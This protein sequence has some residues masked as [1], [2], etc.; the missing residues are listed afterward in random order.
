V[1]SNILIFSDYSGGAMVRWDSPK[2]NPSNR[3][4]Y[5]LGVNVYRAYGKDDYDLLN[6]SAVI[7]TTSYTDNRVP[8]LKTI[9]P[10]SIQQLSKSEWQLELN[11]IPVSHDYPFTPA[12]Q[13]GNL[14]AT[15]DLIVAYTGY[16]NPGRIPVTKIK[17]TKII[18]SD[19]YKLEIPKYEFSLSILSKNISEYDI[20]YYSKT[21][22][23]DHN[24]QLGYMLGLVVVSD[25]TM[26]PIGGG[27][28]VPSGDPVEIWRSDITYAVSEP[29]DYIWSTA[30]FY[31]LWLYNHVCEPV[32]LL[33]RKYT[34]QYCPD[35]IEQLNNSG[36][37]KADCPVC[38]GTGILGGYGTAMAIKITPM[39]FTRTKEISAGGH[40][41][42]G[43][44]TV[45]CLY[46]VLINVEDILIRQNGDRYV[47]NGVEYAGPR[48]DPMIQ[49]LDVSIIPRG[50]LRYLASITS[51]DRVWSRN[52]IPDW[53]EQKTKTR[54]SHIER[55]TAGKYGDGL[56]T[57][58]DETLNTYDA[59]K[60]F[61]ELN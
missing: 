16:G 42:I 10:V 41:D 6:P 24:I 54:D 35:C 45:E 23:R 3:I 26:S 2:L 20:S 58:G 57:E 15:D 49:N 59:I 17:Q 36:V 53:L 25:G 37:A 38:F 43:D 32:Y 31:N 52:D 18:I 30:A 56:R 50:D 5:R 12:E 21:D 7:T 44:T 8:L 48:G 14:N 27:A 1:I 4:Y 55:D 13:I 19:Y 61:P 29:M 40:R 22:F 60:D 46:P 11:D 28:V 9:H 33:Q 34:G 51:K 39:E 47:V